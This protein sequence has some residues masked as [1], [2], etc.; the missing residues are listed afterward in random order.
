MS[1]GKQVST[2]E[3][4]SKTAAE[5]LQIVELFK[6]RLV[7]LPSEDQKF[8]VRPVPEKWS[9]QEI[10]GH[11]IDSA[12]NNHQKFVRLMQFDELDFPGYAQDE[13]V[14]L[15]ACS[16]ME[17]NEMVILWSSFNKHLAHVMR[18]VPSEQLT[19]SITI[20]GVGP[21]ELGFVMQDYVEHLKHHLRQIFP[22]CELQSAFKNVYGA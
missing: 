10:L 17:W 20:N 7:G 14:L 8:A 2:S 21:F 6:P 15:Q 4:G 16:S 9:K 19:N 22:G 12:S 13:W 5:L 1:E 3:L 11:L 18:Q